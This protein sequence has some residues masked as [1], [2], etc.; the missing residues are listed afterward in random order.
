MLKKRT[1]QEAVRLADRR[2]ET[3]FQRHSVISGAAQLLRQVKDFSGARELLDKELKSTDTPWYYQSSYANLEQ[4]AGKFAEALVWAER[5]RQSAK[6]RATKLQWIVTD[7]TMTAKL[8]TDGQEER[9]A[10]LLTEYY[11]AAFELADGFSG[12]NA[13]RAKIVAKEIKPW[14]GRE[15]LKAVVAAYRGRCNGVKGE[16]KQACEEHFAELL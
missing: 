5:A 2:A 13:Y 8:P 1:V 11:K 4:D 15:S 7:L 12:R 16:A 14:A 6:G 3:A 9:L 10:A